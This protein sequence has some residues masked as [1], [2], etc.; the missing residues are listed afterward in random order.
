MGFSKSVNYLI[1]HPFV[2]KT[3]RLPPLLVTLFEPDINNSL[4]TM[5]KILLRC[6]GNFSDD[7]E[8]GNSQVSVNLSSESVRHDVVIDAMPALGQQPLLLPEDL[9]TGY[10]IGNKFHVHQCQAQKT[11]EILPSP[12]CHLTFILPSSDL[13]GWILCEDISGH[14]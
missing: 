3:V 8:G 10:K 6:F 14:I 1:E 4:S 11:L 5:F 9:K 13:I 2:F 7:S 12:D